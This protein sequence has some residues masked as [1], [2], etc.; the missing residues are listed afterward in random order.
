MRN[1]AKNGMFDSDWTPAPSYSDKYDRIPMSFWYVLRCGFYSHAYFF[2]SDSL[3]LQMTNRGNH[4]FFGIQGYHLG[5]IEMDRVLLKSSRG[6]IF[7]LNHTQVIA[8][9]LK[10]GI[11]LF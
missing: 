6:S 9:V 10:A 2:G 4:I 11:Y 1:A 5:K 3:K 8:L 7:L